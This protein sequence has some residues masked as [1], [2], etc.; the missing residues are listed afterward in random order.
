MTYA[1]LHKHLFSVTFL[2]CM[3]LYISL[4]A[5]FTK[6][7]RSGDPVLRCCVFVLL[8]H[9]RGF[10]SCCVCQSKLHQVSLSDLTFS[11]LMSLLL[12]FPSQFAHR[13]DHV[14][15][16]ILPTFVNFERCC[17]LPH[18]RRGLSGSLRKLR[19][20]LLVLCFIIPVRP[21]KSL[22]PGLE[23]KSFSHLIGKTLQ[24]HP[25]LKAL[26]WRTSIRCASEPGR[27]R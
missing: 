8:A 5:H 17:L 20:L 26:P 11:L 13:V 25:A 3:N 9:V 24:L 12:P 6:F 21:L 10:L 22:V 19:N 18:N 23:V 15:V 1:L 16:S 7:L 4:L 27:Q 14:Q 2:S